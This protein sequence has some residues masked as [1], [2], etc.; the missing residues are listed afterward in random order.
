MSAQTSYNHRTQVA[1]AGGIVDLAPYAIDAF[2]NEAENGKMKFG[3]GVVAGTTPGRNFN[4]PTSDSTEDDFL[5]VTVNGRT[6][7]WNL[8]GDILIRESVSLGVMAY[9]R[10]FCRVAADTDVAFND[11]CYLI[12]DGDEAGYFTN[13]EG[14]GAFEVGR[15]LGPCD[16]TLQIAPVE[17]N[18]R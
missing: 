14:A 5:G 7:E 16:P 1:V 4:Y 17:L 9:G 8:E 6:T 10:I 18:K 13:D 15:F 2:I 3:V 12:T 11:K